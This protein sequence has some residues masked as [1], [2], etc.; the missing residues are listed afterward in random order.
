MLSANSMQQ[1]PHMWSMLEDN[2]AFSQWLY[3]V[4]STTTKPHNIVNAEI[5]HNICSTHNTEP[6][7]NTLNMYWTK[8]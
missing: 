8:K 2:T 7:H 5:L 1:F 3:N 4:Y 6:L